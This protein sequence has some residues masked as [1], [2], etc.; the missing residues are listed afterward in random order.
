MSHLEL[1][2]CDQRVAVLQCL[3]TFAKQVVEGVRHVLISSIA[4]KVVLK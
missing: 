2:H 4:E 1:Q 3:L